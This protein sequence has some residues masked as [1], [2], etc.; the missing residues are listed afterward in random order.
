MVNE[1]FEEAVD[2]LNRVEG[3]ALNFPL[4]Y[5][6]SQIYGQSYDTVAEE[7]IQRK[8]EVI[9]KLA[10]A[11]KKYYYFLK[12]AI[13]ATDDLQLVRLQEEIKQWISTST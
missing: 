13:G 1:Q 4:I 9:K 3:S 12:L 8:V 11:K 7:F 5:V 2:Y 10:V 6:T